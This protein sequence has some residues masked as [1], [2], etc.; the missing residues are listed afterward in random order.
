MFLPAAAAQTK[1]TKFVMWCSSDF[2]LNRAPSRLGCVLVV[3]SVAFG[4]CRPVLISVTGSPLRVVQSSV[5]GCVSLCECVI[6]VFKS[7]SKNQYTVTSGTHFMSGVSIVM[8]IMMKA[9]SYEPDSVL[10]SNKETNINTL[11]N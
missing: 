5:G 6:W 3:C 10:I 2:T 8:V 7:P 1:C 11:D 9:N 4:L